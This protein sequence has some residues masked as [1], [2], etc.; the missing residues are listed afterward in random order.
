MVAGSSG[1]GSAP[2]MLRTEWIRGV[3]ATMRVVAVWLE[4]H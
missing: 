4:L 1:H 3:E 2:A